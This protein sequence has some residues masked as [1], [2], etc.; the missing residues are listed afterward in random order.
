MEH[1]FHQ[2]KEIQKRPTT[3]EKIIAKQD[4]IG[5]PR[6]IIHT[7]IDNTFI[8]ADGTRRHTSFV[9][10]ETLQKHNIPI[11]AIT[12]AS[13]SSVLE[14]I[15]KGELPYSQIISSK[16][17]TERYI[18]IK[19]YGNKKYI[20]DV[21]WDEKMRQ[22]GYDRKTVVL[23]LQ[24]LIE[25]PPSEIIG[26]TF[27]NPSE[28]EEFL[29]SGITE[30]PFK[31]SC[32]FFSSDPNEAAIKIREEF[33]DC[34]VVICEEINHN[35][36]IKPGE[37]KKWCLD[38]LPITKSDAV[39]SVSDQYQT[40]INIIAGDSGND[41]EMILGEG[42]ISIVVGGAK[43]E[44]V[45]AL[46][47]ALGFTPLKS[48]TRRYESG[49]QRFFLERSEKRKGPESIVYA[50]RVL[51]RFARIYWQNLVGFYKDK[52]TSA[53]TSEQQQYLTTLIEDLSK[54]K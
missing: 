44:L 4:R 8:I 27:Q 53:I 46:K 16:V 21:S 40:E 1:E 49:N 34:R 6:T 17:G 48:F 50:L 11:H 12:G 37:P 3:I 24:K 13:F 29:K 47:N 41:K 20:R 36:Q 26:F 45:D 10:F 7:D 51:S 38:I 25:K 31:T 39:N 32:Y 9:L 23:K 54:I 43:Q 22:T 2:Q 52:Q 42:D 28:E 35:R 19:Q 33:P 14:R 30:Q 5:L 18:L 15:K